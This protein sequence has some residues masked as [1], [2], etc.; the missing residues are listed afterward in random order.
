MRIVLVSSYVPF[1]RGGGRFIVEWLE[2]KLREHGHDV[3]RFYLPFVDSPHDLLDQVAAFR[4][5]NLSESADRLI[6]FRPPSHVLR[7]P[8]KVLWFIHH[9]RTFYD[10]WGTRYQAVPNTASGR[11]VRQQLVDLDTQT[12]NEAV[13][14]YTNSKIVADR[15]L[16]FNGIRATPLY[17]PILQPER[18]WAETYDEEIAFVCRIE[19]HKRQQLMLD[20]MRYTRSDVRLAIYGQASSPSHARELSQFVSAHSLGNKVK[21]ENR[22]I[23][24]DE[25]AQILSRALA[26]AYTPLDEDSYGYPSLEAAHSRKCI[27]TTTDS[28]GV[29][30]LIENE[31]NG[32]VLPPDPVAIAAGLDRLYQDRVL[33][34]RMGEANAARLA[35][36]KIDWSHVVQ[37]L[38]T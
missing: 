29:L 7:H 3:E 4:L 13:K 21:I 10:L 25:K 28:G 2:T 1:V 31:R 9:I 30:E 34:R 19:A 14:I 6:A 8:N 20:A 23:S 12:I 32:M 22:W 37:S 24:E 33:A 27:V 35:E 38:T 26:V 18:F 15:L 36:L 11:A 16:R 17:P 5:M